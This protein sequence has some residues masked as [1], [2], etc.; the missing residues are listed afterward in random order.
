MAMVDQIKGPAS[1]RKRP[2][3][4]RYLQLLANRQA[5]GGDAQPPSWPSQT[6]AP[7]R[8]GAPSQTVP[9]VLHQQACQVRRA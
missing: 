3:Q 1:Q 4:C 9:L 8:K 5:A 6:H 2:C 7:L